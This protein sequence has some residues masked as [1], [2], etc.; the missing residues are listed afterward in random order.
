MQAIVKAATG[1]TMVLLFSGRGKDR[2]GDG[3]G[4]ALTGAD[5]SV[6]PAGP[7]G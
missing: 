7:R 3:G 2:L 6:V 5:D 4:G 1:A